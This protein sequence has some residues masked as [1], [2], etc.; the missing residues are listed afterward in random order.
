MIFTGALLE[1]GISLEVHF[2]TAKPLHALFVH[3]KRL[4]NESLQS[5]ARKEYFLS[6][7]FSVCYEAIL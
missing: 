3:V 2:Y 1:A 7:P 4:V 5:R 6:I